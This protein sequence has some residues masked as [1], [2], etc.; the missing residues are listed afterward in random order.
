MSFWIFPKKSTIDPPY[1]CQLSRHNLPHL[2]SHPGGGVGDLD[3]GII[4]PQVPDHTAAGKGGGQDVLHLP[5]GEGGSRLTI[6]VNLH[7]QNKEKGNKIANI[8][9]TYCASSCT[10]AEFNKLHY[11]AVC[12]GSSTF[13]NKSTTGTKAMCKKNGH[14]GI[15]MLMHK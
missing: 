2:A 15:F 9:K 7:T 5:G 4:L 6:S 8:V 14:S 10:I 3:D 12:R 13:Y 1:L 11:L